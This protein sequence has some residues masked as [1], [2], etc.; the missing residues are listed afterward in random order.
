MSS[1]LPVAIETILQYVILV[2]FV[3]NN[4]VV[5]LQEQFNKTVVVQFSQLSRF[6][7]RTFCEHLK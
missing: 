1:L 7:V 3:I 5:Y 2:K 4:P 6:L